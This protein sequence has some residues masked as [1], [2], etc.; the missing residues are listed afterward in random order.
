VDV[1]EGSNNLVTEAMAAFAAAEA[2][3]SKVLSS[4]PDHA[5]AHLLLARL[6]GFVVG[7]AGFTIFLDC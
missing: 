2:K 5:H 1:A 4:V 7:S 6:R 3:F